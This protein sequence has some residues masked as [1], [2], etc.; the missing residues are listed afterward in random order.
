MQ[1]FYLLQLVR[2]GRVGGLLWST[3][4]FG[5]GAGKWTHAVRLRELASCA[6]VCNDLDRVCA[7][8][9]VC[10]QHP[11]CCWICACVALVAVM[12]AEGI[13][14]HCCV[15][16]LNVIHGSARGFFRKGNVSFAKSSGKIDK[17]LALR[18]Y[19]RGARG[20]VPRTPFRARARQ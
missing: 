19:H 20:P 10:W 1:M 8:L 16:D 6:H 9:G 14:S 13:A 18:R 11:R 3:Y 5:V 7:G 17:Q 2:G 4:F 12:A 15:N